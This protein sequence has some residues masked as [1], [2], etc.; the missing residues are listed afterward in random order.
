MPYSFFINNYFE[1]V[2]ITWAIMSLLLLVFLSKTDFESS[3]VHQPFQN[4]LS[5]C[6]PLHLLLSLVFH[7]IILFSPIYLKCY[8]YFPWLLWLVLTHSSFAFLLTFPSLKRVLIFLVVSIFHFCLGRD[9][10]FTD[11]WAAPGETTPT[12]PYPIYF[13]ISKSYSLVPFREASHSWKMWLGISD[14]YFQFWL[15]CKT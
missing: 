15:S 5:F 11:L 14:C 13:H 8:S 2:L 12:S 9:L 6:H 1:K 7:S 3:S 4:Q 10:A